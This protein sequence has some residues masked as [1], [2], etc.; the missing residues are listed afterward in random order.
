MI[1]SSFFSKGLAAG[2]TSLLLMVSFTPVFAMEKKPEE[3]ATIQLAKD[4][5]SAVL[6][7]AATGQVLFE[8]NSH[9]KLPP[10]SVTKV[11]TMLLIMEAVDSGKVKWSDK[12]K[13][14]ENAASM[15][16]SQ[17]FL[18]VGEEMT[19][20]EMMK[21]IA[22]ASGNDASVAVAEHLAGSV[23]EFV[24]QMNER[25]AQLG[26]KDTHFANVNGLPVENH[27]SSAYDIAVISRELLKHER[28]LKWTS[29][30]SDYL[31]KG[32]EKPFWLVNTN[33]LVRFYQGM[34][35]L[36]TGFTAE[37]RY[38]LSATAKRDQFRLISVVMG[39]P[40]SPIRNKE[41]SQMM[42]WGF[43]NYRSE[44]VY[45]AGQVVETALVDKGETPK[46]PLVAKDTVGVV[47]KKGQHKEAITRQV[48]IGDIQAPLHK[49]QVVGVI[50]A[51]RKG[52]IVAKSD[53]VVASDVPKARFLTILGRT[54]ND[55][56]AL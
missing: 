7:D 5:R 40:T 4:S 16:G 47:V 28:I 11:M 29:I 2:L 19:L 1:R 22:V 27:Y 52:E 54:I 38:C 42:D 24:R 43:A 13:T 46:V 51:S 33:K 6:M 12:I 45:K 48:E 39:A 10:A 50:T 23:D 20:E 36:K 34:D 18:Q 41:I 8:K 30:Y 3:S 21:G 15:G 35:G 14:S 9:E 56:L 17:I 26:L 37:A 31:R 25:A 44:T 53:I 32:S 49:G 55:W